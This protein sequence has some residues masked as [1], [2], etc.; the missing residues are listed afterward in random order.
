M[1]PTKN[2]FHC[3]A[4]QHSKMLF[5]SRQEA[6]RFLQYNAD[7]IE[8]KTGKRPVRTYYCTACCGWHVT[9]RPY[10]SAYHSLVNRYG[11]IEG[12]KI[13]DEVTFIKGK[14]Q[15]IKDGLGRKI[16]QLRHIL[17]TKKSMWIDAKS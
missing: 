7:E 4:C 6:I 15:G 10:S 9:S 3:P 12:Q 11:D 2:K 8:T 14:R 17:N 5:T 1:K 13:F 16:K